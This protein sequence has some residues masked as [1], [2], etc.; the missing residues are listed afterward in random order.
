VQELVVRFQQV[1]GP[2]MA[3]G[4]EDT[5]FYRYNRL[6]ALNEVG[7]D[8]ATVEDPGPRRLH[9]W[10]ERQQRDF[11]LGMT[12][13]S[14]HDTKRSEDVRARLL[15][16]A[17]DPDAWSAVW[18]DVSA[19][20]GEHLVDGSTAYLLFQ[21]LLGAW[22]ID[23]ERL[24]G[25]LVKAMREAKRHTTWPDPDEAYE[26]RVLSL[27][28]D[29]LRAGPVGHLIAD[30][31]ARHHRRIAAVTLAGKLLQ[32]TLP[33]VPDVY[34]GCEGLS[35]SLVDPDNRRPVDFEA[36]R[37][38]LSRLPATGLGSATS[39]PSARSAEGSGSADPAAP[40]DEA[41]SADKLLVTST[42]LRLR[43][44]KPD[45][46]GAAA[47]YRRLA[48]SSGVVA[49]ARSHGDDAF[50]TVVHTADGPGVSAEVTLPGGR[51]RSAF[52]H[53]S[54]EGGPRNVWDLST[55]VPVALLLK[56]TPS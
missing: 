25:Y 32:L 24:C 42:V 11:P 55:P 15:A 47:A 28:Q 33:G 54:F 35:L 5:T 39:A 1:C 56:E 40:A 38:R 2:V 3:K 50:V 17:A 4:V 16:V 14:T 12:T 53:S 20:A 45:L 49:F 27:A 46:F 23:E 6:L 52:A 43:R 51:W 18:A 36:L 41:L 21:T 7:G 34:Q 48:A 30:A 29:C 13:L 19:R 31:L 44:R 22:P 10:A 8:P 26:R 37:S 9:D